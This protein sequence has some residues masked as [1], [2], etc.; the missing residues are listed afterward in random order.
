MGGVWTESTAIPLNP[1]SVRQGSLV[2]ERPSGSF[3]ASHVRELNL[4]HCERAAGEAQRTRDAKLLLPADLRHTPTVCKQLR[5]HRGAKAGASSP[6]PRRGTPRRLPQKTQT[7]GVRDVSGAE[8]PRKKSVVANARP[9]W[10]LHKSHEFGVGKGNS[11]RL[12]RVGGSIAWGVNTYFVRES[13][14]TAVVLSRQGSGQHQE[15][16]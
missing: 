3:L 12:H 13:H 10:G 5:G 4:S 2:K 9:P 16:D 11:S 7:P 1:T 8:R 15:M 14:T 6:A